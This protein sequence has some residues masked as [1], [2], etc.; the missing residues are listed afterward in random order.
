MASKL[1]YDRGTTYAIT[2]NYQENGV[3]TDITGASIF[4]T[5]KESEYDTNATDSTALISKT[6]TSHTTPLSGI[7]TITI[8]PTDSE[9]IT[10]GNY[11]YDIK[12]KKAGAQIYKLV[13]GR[14]IID[15]SPTNRQ[16]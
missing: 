5:V 12:I 1:T 3:A 9:D 8:D 14:F 4:F 15:A 10:P 6:V 11:Y 7:S 13:E 2:V 16:V